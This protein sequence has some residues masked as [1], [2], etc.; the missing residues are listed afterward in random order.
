MST[1]NGSND[2][3]PRCAWARGGDTLYIA[4]H[5][6]EWG[7]PSFQDRHLFEMLILEGFQA[8]L[9]WRT[10]LFKREAFR[11]AFDGFD[12]EKVARY[13]P[14]KTDEL[15]QNQGIV[16]NRLKIL[17]A[18]GNAQAFLS[19][20]KEYGSFSDYLWGWVDKKPVMLESGPVPTK[21]PLSDAISFDL[22]RRG[23]RFVGSVIIYS[24]LQAVGVVNDHEPGC[25]RR[26]SDA[27]P[28]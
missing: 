14:E 4:Y 21:T 12:P 8:G 9:S 20:Q 7:T 23:M 10:I 5:D 28:G 17:S 25:F 15:M 26:R 19:I 22:K 27:Q 3:L 11:Q 1:M 24:F 18:A 6:G 16:R 13:G 2:V